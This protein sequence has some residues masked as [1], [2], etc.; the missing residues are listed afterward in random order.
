MTNLENNKLIAKFMGD[1]TYVRDTDGYSK[2]LS[3][4]NSKE[5]SFDTDWNWLML[6]VDKIESLQ[7]T[8]RAISN[9]NP[10]QNKNYHEVIVEK[11]KGELSKSKTSFNSFGYVYKHHSNGLKRIDCYFESV[12]EFIKWYNLNN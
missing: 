5:L 7:V 3:V 11:E 4:F 1:K 10:F 8:I 2:P 9:F 6:V 12:V